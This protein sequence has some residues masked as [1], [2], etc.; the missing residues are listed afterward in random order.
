VRGFADENAGPAAFAAIDASVVDV[1]AYVGLEYRLLD[2]DIK[3]V[4]ETRA[5]RHSLPSTAQS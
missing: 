2:L 4:V 5:Q 1:S 3:Q